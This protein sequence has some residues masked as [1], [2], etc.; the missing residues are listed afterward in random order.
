MTFT[1]RPP[2]CWRAKI[3]RQL[4]RSSK[5]MFQSGPTTARVF[6]VWAL[7]SSRKQHY[8]EATKALERSLQIDPKL[9]DAE[10]QLGVVADRKGAAAEAL[11]HFDRAVQLQPQHAKALASL[12]GQYLQAGEF[13]KG[14]AV[15]ERSIAIN[16]NDPKAQYDLALVLS[17]LGKSEE[18]R[19]HMERSP[20][21]Q[22]SGG[23]GEESGRGRGQT[24]SDCPHRTCR[25][26]LFVC[27]DLWGSSLFTR[28]SE[29][30]FLLNRALLGNRINEVCSQVW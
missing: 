25:C 13:E 16:P 22:D 18:A 17:K 14:H 29:R 9:A 4:R 6:S 10:Y 1:W 2:L 30:N 7:R 21:A 20:R 5:T 11:Q 23:P 19:Q 3:S 27:P 8:P 12:G 15:L 24:V 28:L 26:C